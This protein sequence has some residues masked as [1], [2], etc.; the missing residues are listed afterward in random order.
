MESIYY[1]LDS[2]RDLADEMG[3]ICALPSSDVLEINLK[4]NLVLIFENDREGND[5]YLGFRNSSWHTHGKLMFSLNG[6]SSCVEFDELDIVSGL[7]SGDVLVCEQ[8]RDGKLI[9][10]WLTHK[11]SEVDTKYMEPGEE[12]HI[13]RWSDQ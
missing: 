7:K 12:L 2:L 11:E 10:R 8:Y 4:P 3:F 1:D 13:W 5:T 9:D 6:N